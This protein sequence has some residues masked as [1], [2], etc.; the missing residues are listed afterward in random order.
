MIC[1]TTS[2]IERIITQ[3]LDNNCDILCLDSEI[4]VITSRIIEYKEKLMIFDEKFSVEIKL[5]EK[6]LNKVLY[7][8]NQTKESLNGSSIKAKVLD[9]ELY[10]S[11]ENDD[12][13]SYHLRLL[14]NDFEINFPPTISSIFS[15][16]PRQIEDENE[17]YLK[18]YEIK[19]K[20]TQ[21]I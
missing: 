14:I 17:I 16:P 5:D 15:E 18:I 21:V 20:E 12:I 3:Y 1:K 4:K 2:I 6:R 7:E 10:H 11:I 19:F 9:I 8:S 13:I